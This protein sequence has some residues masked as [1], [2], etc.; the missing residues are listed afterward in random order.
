MEAPELEKKELDREARN[1]EFIA[2]LKLK[3]FESIRKAYGLEYAENWK[4]KYN[5]EVGDSVVTD[6]MIWT[7]VNFSGDGMTVYLRTTQ[8]KV[9]SAKIDKVKKHR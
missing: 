7:V 6:G 3:V 5:I 9:G 8:G 1:K 4:L 2:S